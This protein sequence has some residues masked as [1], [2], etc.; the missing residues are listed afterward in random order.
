MTI[1][2]YRNI[3]DHA[4]AQSLYLLSKKKEGSLKKRLFNLAMNRFEAAVTAIPDDSLTLT[5]WGDALY[6]NFK[7]TSIPADKNEAIEKYFLAKNI[8]K[9]YK[10]ADD[11]IYNSLSRTHFEQARLFYQSAACIYRRAIET[12]VRVHESCLRLA[13]LY[14]SQTRRFPQFD[15][16]HLAGEQI[17]KII[18]LKPELFPSE[19]VQYA[20]SLSDVDLANLAEILNKNPIENNEVKLKLFDWRFGFR[21]TTGS[22]IKLINISTCITQLIL[23]NLVNLMDE[24]FSLMIQNCPKLEILDLRNCTLI[25]DNSI[26]E[27]CKY[28]TNLIYLDLRGCSQISNSSLEQL[29]IILTTKLQSLYLECKR[30][31]DDAIENCVKQSYKLKELVLNRFILHL[32]IYF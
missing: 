9:L 4:E 6:T 18:E 27:L 25:T 10:I 8:N 13:N 17:R 7:E 26:S 29:S 5:A 14:I 15:G 22:I 19:L 1:Y 30:I 16:F 20:T 31:T 28:C 2:F 23:R 24:E 21:M 11:E 12:E 32:N 3:V